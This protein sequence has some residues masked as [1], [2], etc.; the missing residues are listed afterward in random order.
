MISSSSYNFPSIDLFLGA[1]NERFNVCELN[2][3]LF[4]F[5]HECLQYCLMH[6]HRFSYR[7]YEIS[8]TIYCSFPHHS[9]NKRKTNIASFIDFIH[10]F[11]F[12]WL[13]WTMFSFVTCLHALITPKLIFTK[14]TCL[15]A[16]FYCLAVLLLLYLNFH[17][18]Y[19]TAS[20]AALFIYGCW[21][22]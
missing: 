11:H 5:S 14:Y 20:K 16:I 15:F 7:N 17:L 9:K 3:H 4:S 8:E 12:I 1:Q 10:F 21:N 19:G 22:C 18:V 13:L 6:H 2:F